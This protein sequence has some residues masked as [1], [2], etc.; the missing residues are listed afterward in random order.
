[1]P[2]AKIFVEANVFDES[3]LEKLSQ[4]IRRS[5]MKTLKNVPPE[6]FFQIVSDLP[7][8]RFFHPPAFLGHAYTKEFILLELTFMSGQTEED[9]Q[10]LLKDLN[11]RVVADVGIAPDDLVTLSFEIAPE[12]F[13]FGRG[14]PGPGTV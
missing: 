2:L 10:A 1:M 9:R 7:K 4:A 12:N 11:R 13:T 6:D 8:T 5:L 14:V 3:R